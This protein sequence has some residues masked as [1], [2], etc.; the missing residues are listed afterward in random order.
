MLATLVVHVSVIV[1]IVDDYDNPWSHGLNWLI[2]MWCLFIKGPFFERVKPHY[3]GKKRLSW[4]RQTTNIYL[5]WF[6]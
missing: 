5:K 2:T 1:P 3:G 4:Y 6:K